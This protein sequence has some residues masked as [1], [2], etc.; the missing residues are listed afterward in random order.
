MTLGVAGTNH[1]GRVPYSDKPLYLATMA[2]DADGQLVRVEVDGDADDLSLLPGTRA[3]A[4][5][6]A[7]AVAQRAWL[8]SGS[9]PGTGT[10]WEGMA[11]DA[12]LDLRT[13][14]LDDGAVLAAGSGPW[15]YAWPRDGA[16]VAVAYARTGHLDDARRVLA[17]YQRAQAGDGTVEA[18]Y[19]PDGS[20]PPDDRAPQ[21]DGIGWLLWALGQTVD[22]APTAERSAVLAQF[23]PLLDRATNAAVRALGPTGLPAPSPDYWE[24]RE[25]TVTLGTAAPLLAG[26]RA[27]AHLSGLLGDDGGVT[28]ANAAAR[29]LDAAIEAGFAPSYGRYPGSGKHDAAVAFLL[30]PFVPASESLAAGYGGVDTDD[31]AVRVALHAAA[32]QMA[33]PGGGLAPGAHWP[34]DGVS[35]TPETALVALGAASGDTGDRALATRLLD[36]LDDHRTVVGSFPEKVLHDGS[37]A[38]TAPLVW[39]SATVLLTLATLD[40][41]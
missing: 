11:R 25:D 34:Q 17:F 27:S 9:V 18:R 24:K 33:R 31:G 26:L 15:R 36:W 39:T 23:Q 29:R 38:G 8:A 12:L 14:T 4:G 37:P 1:L 7:E 20:G 6:T 21:T 2:R 35:W 19:L 3:V 13:M 28:A 40:A 41:R 10:R 32:A 30:P 22:A 5:A 16:F